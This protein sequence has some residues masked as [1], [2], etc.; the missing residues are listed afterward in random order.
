M[1]P[2]A[3][4]KMTNMMGEMNGMAVAWKASQSLESQKNPEIPSKEWILE[5]K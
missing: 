2:K 1:C 3:Q 5:K 4:V